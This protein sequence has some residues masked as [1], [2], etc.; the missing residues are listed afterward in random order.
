MS[1]NDMDSPESGNGKFAF[2]NMGDEPKVISQVSL[3]SFA[4][5][6]DPIDDG[7]A[8]TVNASKKRH[9]L[10]LW[11]VLAVMLLLGAVAGG[12]YWFFQSH[13]LPGVTLWGKSMTGQSRDH[14]IQEIS[15]TAESLTVPVSYE[16]TSKK[17]TLKDLGVAIDAESIAEN[18]MNAKRD[19]SFFQK[20]AFWTREDVDVESFDDSRVSAQTVGDMLGVQSLSLI[21][22]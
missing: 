4:E 1:L 22:I 10:W 19:D 16:G 2:P 7:A 21:H 18:V 8:L 6:A 20:Y 12:G 3:D 15:D 11:I 5:T 17:V 13:A 9:L 14:I